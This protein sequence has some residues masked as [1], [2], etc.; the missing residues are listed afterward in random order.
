MSELKS[1]L[2]HQLLGQRKALSQEVWRE[3]SDRLCQHLLASPPFQA[4]TTILSYC[5]FRQEPDLTLLWQQS[6]KQWGLP[7]SVGKSL[8]WHRWQ[9]SEGLVQGKYGIF[10]P[11]P[12]S[13][14]LSGEE[15]D[16]IL[17]P[18]VGCDRLGYRLGYGGGFYDRLLA[19]PPWCNIPTIG[20]IFHFALSPQ[21]PRDSWDRP[22]QFI[23][24]EQAF[25]SCC[26]D[27]H[28]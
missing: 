15:V 26:D 5:S 16:L 1:T 28:D 12:D 8:I 22:L 24:T 25:L 21:L 2:R 9:P 17:V 18:A 10:E 13:T 3:K 23:C 27:H 4:A 20:I 6:E 14:G 11:H 7:R 19:D